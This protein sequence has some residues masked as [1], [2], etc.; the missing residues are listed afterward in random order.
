MPDSVRLQVLKAITDL[1]GTST[2]LSQ[3]SVYRG[4]LK[5][6]VGD[7]LPRVSILES[8]K[9]GATN[10]P[11]GGADQKSIWELY[12]QGFVVDEGDHPTDAAHDLLAEVK[13][14]LVGMRIEESEFYR[15]P[16]LGEDLIYDVAIDGGICRPPD[17]F[18]NEAYFLLNV[19]LSLIEDLENPY[20]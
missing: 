8:P 16:W 7:S 15:L 3:G 18:C 20:G 9:Q 10:H 5:F 6:G 2:M 1:I 12:L 11:E 4:R 17:E 19:R 14:L 13:R